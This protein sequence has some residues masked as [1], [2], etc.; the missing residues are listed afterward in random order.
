MRI[1]DVILLTKL[2]IERYCAKSFL[3]KPYNLNFLA[4]ILF[5]NCH[6]VCFHSG[7]TWLYRSN[8]LITHFCLFIYISS[9][10]TK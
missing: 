6:M 9:F 4:I 2:E 1:L 8:S 3:V 5:T 7:C 10:C